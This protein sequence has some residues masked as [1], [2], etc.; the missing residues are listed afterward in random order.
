MDRNLE[1]TN[2]IC[3][4]CKNV[5]AGISIAALSGSEHGWLVQ[6]SYQHGSVI[7]SAV[8]DTLLKCKVFVNFVSTVV[9]CKHSYRNSCVLHTDS[10]W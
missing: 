8:T 2:H 10:H 7:I 3:R 5:W 1:K 6:S 4:G 9:T